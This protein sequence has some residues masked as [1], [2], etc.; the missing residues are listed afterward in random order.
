MTGEIAVDRLIKGIIDADLGAERVAVV[1]TTSFFDHADE[2]ALS[3]EVSMKSAAD[4]PDASRQS[5]LTQALRRSLTE[6]GDV[7]FPYLYFDSLDNERASDDADEFE[8]SL[9]D[10]EQL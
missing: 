8:A 3:V 9:D 7:R 4:I 2:A 6:H 10:P 5:A 1:T